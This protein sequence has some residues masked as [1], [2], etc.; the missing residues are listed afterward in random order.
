MNDKD[1]PVLIKFDVR[2]RMQLILDVKYQNGFYFEQYVI[3]CENSS[4]FYHELFKT[5]RL[6]EAEARFEQYC[7]DSAW[8]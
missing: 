3:V 1:Y 8:C 4:G 7:K 5:I 6:D 2:S